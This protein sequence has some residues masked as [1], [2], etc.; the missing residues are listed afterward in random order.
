M[1]LA[2]L[3]ISGGCSET[4][5]DQ[6]AEVPLDPE[7]VAADEDRADAAVVRIEDLPDGWEAEPG[8]SA[9]DG[10]EDEPVLPECEAME[11]ADERGR[12]AEATSESF[13]RENTQLGSS[14]SFYADDA[15]A[16]TAFA[17]RFEDEVRSCLEEV[18]GTGMEQG[19]A[20][21]PAIPAG[22]AQVDVH[23]GDLSVEA[24]GDERGGWSATVEATVGGVPLSMYADL[25]VVR[26]GRVL[27]DFTTLSFFTPLGE[28]HG[29]I[30]T[31]GVE[32]VTAAL[33]T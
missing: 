28:P 11:E 24:V 16:A 7:L 18:I 20:E 4:S 6:A 25:I 31:A 17:A 1:A 10:E 5:T 22:A 27:I 26:V 2:L 15:L 12:T 30:L 14:V 19:I 8:S 33:A 3:L 32:R 23:V 29:P 21:D 9:D 13:V